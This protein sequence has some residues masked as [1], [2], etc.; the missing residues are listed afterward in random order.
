MSGARDAYPTRRK[1]DRPAR[2]AKHAEPQAEQIGVTRCD[3]HGWL[4]P[5]SP[6]V[7]P[8]WRI[9]MQRAAN[10]SGPA[11]HPPDVTNIIQKP[12]HIP[13]P[14]LLMVQRL[15]EP[16]WPG[17][18]HLHKGSNPG[19]RGLD[20]SLGF[21]QGTETSAS[22]PGPA[23]PCGALRTPPEALTR[24]PSQPGGRLRRHPTSSRA[25]VSTAAGEGS[26]RRWPTMAS[27]LAGPS[28]D[29]LH[30]QWL[31]QP[32]PTGTQPDAIN[33]RSSSSRDQRSSGSSRDVILFEGPGARPGSADQK[34]A[35]GRSSGGGGVS[36]RP[37]D[38]HPGQG[39]HLHPEDF[40][41]QFLSTAA[42]TP[43]PADRQPIV[44]IAIAAQRQAQRPS[45]ARRRG[46]SGPPTG[47][48]PTPGFTCSQAV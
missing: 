30:Q 17:G 4:A 9:V 48:R 37:D 5:S 42:G 8:V 28:A 39:L 34:P 36:H 32:G 3:C 7:S 45:P 38:A 33:T 12:P 14:P 41:P 22:R 16:L 20:T 2:Q 31:L 27:P 15:Y 47:R 11:R 24:G 29:P 26:G 10:P 18:R 1:V 25:P 23:E 19:T 44:P 13:Y 6:G 35:R 43:G 40:G 21:L 46:T